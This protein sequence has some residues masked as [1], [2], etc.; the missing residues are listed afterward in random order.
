MAAMIEARRVGRDQ[1]APGREFDG[2]GDASR[3]AR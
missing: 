1:V 3:P 2:D